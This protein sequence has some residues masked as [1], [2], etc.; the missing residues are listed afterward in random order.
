VSSATRADRAGPRADATAAFEPVGAASLSNQIYGR[1]RDHLMMG[2]LKPH[3]RLRIR[4]LA[5]SLGTS[6]TPVREAVFQLVRDGALELKERHYIRVRGLTLPE[7]VELRDI[8]LSL[9]PLAAE[10]AMANIGAAGIAELAATHA[11]LVEAEASAAW[12]EAITANYEFHLGLYRLSD[13]PQLIEILE[14]LWLRLG[15]MLNH[16][17]PHGHPRYAGRHQHENV[18]DALRRRDRAALAASI[19]DDMLEGG[20]AFVRVLETLDLTEP[21]GPQ[22]AGGPVIPPPNL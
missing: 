3:Q 17:Y 7:Y 4:D 21:P 12:R 19:R 15:P 11:R 2:L 18:L 5:Q 13:M 6:E 10:R 16:L 20:R 9:E 14:R 8:R 1:L 22:A